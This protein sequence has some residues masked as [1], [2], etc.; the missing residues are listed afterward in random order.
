MALPRHILRPMKKIDSLPSEDNGRVKIPV[1]FAQ[2]LGRDK[3]H[4]VR[5]NQGVRKLSL[6]SAALAVDL[7]NKDGGQITIYQ[8]LPHLLKFKPYFCQ[9]CKKRG[10]R[11]K[12]QDE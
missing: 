6:E 9:G 3:S 4:I 8:I 7:F 1:Q 11:K 2:G 12:G 5:V 10:K